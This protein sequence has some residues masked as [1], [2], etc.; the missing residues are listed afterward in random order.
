MG[1]QS[2]L[3]ASR[4]VEV[5]VLDPGEALEDYCPLNTDLESMDARSLKCPC[6]KK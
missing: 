3:R 2:F 1:G 6:D 4:K 5:P